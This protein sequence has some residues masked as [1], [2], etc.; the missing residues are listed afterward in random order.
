MT[1]KNIMNNICN[2]QDI[3]RSQAARNIGMTP[4]AFFSIMNRNSG[5]NIKIGTLVEYLDALMC[6]VV[7]RDFETGEEY[8]L[9]FSDEEVEIHTSKKKQGW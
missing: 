3:S 5:M 2:D 1:L 8:I 6:E 7:I 4:G 9:D